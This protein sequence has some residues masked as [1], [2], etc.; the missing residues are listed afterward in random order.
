MKRLSNQSNTFVRG[1]FCILIV[2]LGLNMIPIVNTISFNHLLDLQVGISLT[3]HD[4]I[5]ILSDSDFGPSGY[6]FSGTGTAEDPYVIE[7]YSIITTSLIG[8]SVS[9]T[10][11][12]FIVRNCYVDASDYGIYIS[13][14]A[15]GTATVV[16][17]TCSNNDEGISIVRSNNST[18]ANNTC[19][20]NADG[21]IINDSDRSTVINNLCTNNVCGIHTFSSYSSIITNNTCKKNYFGIL[22]SASDSCVIKY[23]SLQENENYGVYLLS[24]SVNNVIHHNFF[25]YNNLEGTSQACDNGRTNTW[26]DT[27]TLEGNQWSD[28]AGVASYSID[29]DAESSDPYPLDEFMVPPTS[30]LPSDTNMQIMVFVLGLAFIPLVLIIRKRLKNK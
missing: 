27:N 30:S 28:W 14:V 1:Y 9:G 23:N 16:F 15:D 8:I 12:Y 13:D 17:I 11:K 22:L 29:G 5:N 26:Y 20:N 24:D 4:K 7:G 19:T 25:L 18:V 21:I 2:L 10:T 3:P 6:N